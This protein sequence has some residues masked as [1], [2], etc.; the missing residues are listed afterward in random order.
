[1]KTLLIIAFILPTKL[2]TQTNLIANPSFE[3]I[4]NEAFIGINNNSRIFYNHFGDGNRLFNC[5]E[6]V[7]VNGI[8]SN[9]T[10]GGFEYGIVPD[11]YP[12]SSGNSYFFLPTMYEATVFEDAD[13]SDDRI[14]SALGDEYGLRLQNI[15]NGIGFDCSPPNTKFGNNISAQDGQNYVALLDYRVSTGNLVPYIGTH[16][17]Y[18]LVQNVEYTFSLNAAQ[19]NLIGEIAS[20]E[21]FNDIFGNNVNM[22]NIKVYVTNDNYNQKQKIL[23]IKFENNDWTYFSNPFTAQNNSTRILID[24]NNLGEISLIPFS[25][26]AIS[27]C[28]IDNLKLY[29]TCETQETQCENAN[30]RRDLL[31]AKLEVINLDDPSAL[32]EQ[33]NTGVGY[34]KTIKAKHLDNVKHF[35]MKIND[36]SSG[37][38]IRHIIMD[39]PP[40]EYIWDGKDENGNAAPDDYYLAKIIYISND[41]F[42][43][44]EADSKHFH[45]ESHY[46]IFDV[47]STVGVV[48]GNT[49]IYGL[50][51]VNT[52]TI[53]M[54]AA[55]GTL[56]NSYSIPNPPSVI[57]LSTNSLNTYASNQ[58]NNVNPGAYIFHVTVANN[59]F[60]SSFTLT[61]INVN[62]LF[63]DA[64]VV[65]NQ[66]YDWTPV[67]KPIFGCPFNVG[68]NQ[69]YL[70]PMNCCEGDLYINNVDIWT[71]WDVNIQNN[72]YIGPNVTFMNGVVNNLYAG[73]QIVLLPDQTGVVINTVTLLQ[74]NTFT[75][76]IC[77][78]MTPNQ[79]N[80]EMELIRYT[81]EQ[82]DSLNGDVKI[83]ES[84]LYPN[85]YSGEAELTI[86]FGDRK[87]NV[88][89]FKLEL[90]NSIGVNIPLKINSTSATKLKF[91][92]KDNLVPGVYYLYFESLDEKTTFT[93][94]VK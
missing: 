28:F 84:I 37:N 26:P 79:N 3:G 89:N 15:Q 53:E 36:N 39:Y 86:A 27:G 47:F 61:N 32:P 22:P 18:P 54:F 7:E 40:S 82:K 78:S 56:V 16:L 2:F 75:C 59:C 85:P 60:T 81:L 67:V 10:F 71:E 64:G 63:V 87:V 62:D 55:N 9:P 14:L 31:D 44:E 1:M 58:N 80:D 11:L 49:L 74:P 41:C 65:Y 69:N 70:P 33:G 13:G 46:E 23:D 25:N 38:L 91:K 20:S 19:M 50:G 21:G 48:D 29:E 72:I 17:I 45:K 51:N 35:E 90:S 77:K 52:M 5:W 6:H 92:P 30:Y 57:G 66:V 68:Y 24:F 8:L 73:Q 12:T 42:Y 83:K 93:L 43:I 34:I 76:E 4:N 88:E 94:I